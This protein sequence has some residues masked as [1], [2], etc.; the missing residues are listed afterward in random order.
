MMLK[1]SI[2]IPS[3][4]QGRYIEE[5]I[6][7]IINQNYPDKELIIIDGGSSDNSVD[8]IKKYEKHISY[9]VSEADEGQSDAINKGLNHA[10]GDFVAWMNADD[11]YYNNALLTIFSRPGI[12]DYDFIYGNVCIGT[13]SRNAHPVLNKT[14]PFSLFNLLHFFYSIE[15]IVPSQSV[16][17]KRKF[18]EQHNIKFIE[19]DLHY[20]MDLE[21]Y[22]RI[23][24]HKPKYYKYKQPLSFFR[25]NETTKTGSPNNRVQEEAVQV[26]LNYKNHLTRKEKA[27]LFQTLLF[28]RVLKRINKN[29]I[30]SDTIS[31]LKIAGRV[32]MAVADKRF[33]GLIKMS[34]K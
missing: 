5:T 27:K 28:H 26:L 3:Y 32:P 34:L 14:E 8:I 18:L 11:L 4:N 23:A 9:W 19:N 20:C 16:F 30:R 33:L 31:L 15:Y 1:L 2:I 10:T 29:F 22:C 21:W 24:L 17:V 25:I 13:N 12:I 7:S 6:L